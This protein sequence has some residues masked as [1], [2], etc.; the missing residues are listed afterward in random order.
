MGFG[1]DFEKKLGFG[2][3]RLPLLSADNGDIDYATVNMMVDI[4]IEAGYK[5]FE[6]AFNYHNGNSEKAIRK[7]VVERYQR[8]RFILPIKCLSTR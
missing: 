1:F 4:Y 6:T 5:Y 2:F 8:D 7:C 3:L